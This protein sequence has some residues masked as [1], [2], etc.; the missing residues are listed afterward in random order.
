MIVIDAGHGGSDP[1]AVGP[2]KEKDKN[3]QISTYQFNRFKEL[4]IPVKMSR[5]IDETLTPDERIKRI[6][7]AYGN[8]PNII[9]LSNHT[10]A[11]GGQGAEVIYAL[12]NN[13]TLSR[14]IAKEIQNS[15]Q[16]IRSIYQRKSNVN[17]NN[18]YYFIHRRTGDNETVLVEYGF[19]DNANDAVKLQTNWEAYAEAV[20]KAISSYKGYKYI[21]AGGAGGTFAYIVQSGD[22]LYK[23][24]NKS[25]TTVDAIKQLN[26]LS[27]DLLQIGQ[28]L[29]LP[30]G[31]V[32]GEVSTTYVVKAGDNLSTI[33]LNYGTTVESIK[34]LNGLTSDLLQIGQI[35]KIPTG[36]KAY[37]TYTVKAGDSLYAIAKTYGTNVNSIKVL[38]GLS[39]DLLQIGQ[40]LKIPSD[41]KKYTVKVGD[42]LSVIAYNYGTT[43]EKLKTDNNLTSDVIYPGME[44]IIK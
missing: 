21:P 1:G 24:A 16:N 15:G 6:M 26:N 43:V 20:V 17:P 11:G 37:F 34:Q 35:L 41:I 22:S 40:T 4:G 33:A 8:N 12:R 44:I 13:D 42:S 36:E 30:T 28:I 31:E 14:E 2:F 25:G 10:N 18:D 39:N 29:Y 23:I 38:N 27:S 7:E 5:Y 3:L 9:V 32:S 19:L